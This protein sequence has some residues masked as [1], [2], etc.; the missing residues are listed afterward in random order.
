LH[1]CDLNHG[2]LYRDRTK[3]AAVAD[4][5]PNISQLVAQ[6]ATLDGAQDDTPEERSAHLEGA[7][8]DV[9]NALT[10]VLG[11]LE[12]AEEQAPMGSP[13]ERAVRLARERSLHGRAIALRAMKSNNQG[14]PQHPIACEAFLQDAITG[15]EP[16]AKRSCVQLRTVLAEDARFKGVS[17]PSQALQVVTNLLMNAVSFTPEDCVVTLE[18]ARTD[19]DT[20]LFTVYD[21]GPGFE[22]SK[23]ARVFEG[24]ESTRE[25]GSGI[26]LRYAYRLANQHGGNLRLANPGPGAAFELRW[27]SAKPHAARPRTP[28]TMGLEGMRLLVVEDDAAVSMLLE[29]ALGAKGASVD[30]AF[31][32]SSLAAL[33]VE[34]RYDAALVDLS[35]LE[36][37]VVGSLARIRGSHAHPK[38]VLI[39]GSASSPDRGVLAQASAWVRKP[40]E[41]SDVVAALLEL[42]R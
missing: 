14:V 39:T 41:I 26:G 30:T 20:L 21:E 13:L 17:C 23:A 22:P 37:D 18:A 25:G 15:V 34:G 11:W 6:D 2:K 1:P 36:P 29:T 40:F 28:S 9:A 42:P 3:L 8:H 35:P 33:L 19:N 16:Q 12:V 38:L 4:R 24:L 31:D 32:Q 27:P 7:L 5:Q 10:V